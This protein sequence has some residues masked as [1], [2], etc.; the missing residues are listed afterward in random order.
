MR[1]SMETIFLQ[2]SKP[3]L[4]QSSSSIAEQL[5]LEKDVVTRKANN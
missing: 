1:G 4:R 5:G 3:S 2:C